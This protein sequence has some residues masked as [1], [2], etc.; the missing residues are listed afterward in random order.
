MSKI[1][2][3]REEILNFIIIVQKNDGKLES[4]NYYNTLDNNYNMQSLRR[5]ALSIIVTDKTIKTNRAFTQV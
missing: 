4:V 5:K 1:F 3:P 2:M